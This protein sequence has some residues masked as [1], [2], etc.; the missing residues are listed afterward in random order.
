[1]ATNVS[2]L[3]DL[4]G[5]LKTVVHLKSQNDAF[6]R[7]ILA[8]LGKIKKESNSFISLTDI[9]KEGSSYE[10][11]IIAYTENDIELIKSVNIPKGI[12]IEVHSI[13]PQPSGID[14]VL[15]NFNDELS[16]EELVELYEE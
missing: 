9:I 3:G 13:H 16:L 4:R 12:K 1:M 11:N 15:E 2:D 8:D 10:F 7:K 14:N 6:L 5:T